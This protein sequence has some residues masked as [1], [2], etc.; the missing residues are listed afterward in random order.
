MKKEYFDGITA[1]HPKRQ[2]E[3]LKDSVLCDGSCG[4]SFLK[5][6]LEKTAYNEWLCRDC[7][8]TFLAEQEDYIETN[9]GESNDDI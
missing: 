4:I 7:M 8:F 6:D 2:N 1:A 5:K 9:K 3:I